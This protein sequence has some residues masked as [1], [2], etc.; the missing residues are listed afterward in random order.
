MRNQFD[1]AVDLCLNAMKY[2][3]ENDVKDMQTLGDINVKI[4][5]IKQ[6]HAELEEAL[7]FL[8]KAKDIYSECIQKDKDAAK[9]ALGVK[10]VETM[11]GMANIYVDQREIVKASEV[12]KVRE[13]GL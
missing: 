1:E 5:S 13:L 11:T 6:G 2:V 9:Q 10:L 4:S 12:Y 7:A 3:D 8:V